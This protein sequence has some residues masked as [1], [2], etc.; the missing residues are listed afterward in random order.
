MVEPSRRSRSPRLR[1]SVA[2]LSPS[3]AVVQVAPRAPTERSAQ[4]PFSDRL[5]PSRSREPAAVARGSRTPSIRVPAPFRGADHRQR[6]LDPKTFSSAIPPKARLSRRDFSTSPR[7]F[8]K[9][10]EPVLETPFRL[11][12][13][14]DRSSP[15]VSA[16]DLASTELFPAVRE[17]AEGEPVAEVTG[18][19]AEAAEPVAAQLEMPVPQGAPLLSI[20][21]REVAVGV[22]E[23]TA[24]LQVA[25][26]LRA[27][28]AEAV[29]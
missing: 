9:V 1:R 5:L 10:A 4:T 13:A 29:S 27:A 15:E 16:A 14:A 17:E 22:R 12:A 21:A 6:A 11:P 25:M 18:E 8:R 23:V 20:R 7:G 3:A 19:P 28:T 2:S 26:A 24:L